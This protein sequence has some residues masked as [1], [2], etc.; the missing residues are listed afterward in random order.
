[1]KLYRINKILIDKDQLLHCVMI[2]H[3]KDTMSL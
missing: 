1:M 2:K 3:A